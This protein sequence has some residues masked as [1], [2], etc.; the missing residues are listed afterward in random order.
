MGETS[1]TKIRHRL[2]SGASL[3]EGP[4]LPARATAFTHL[5]AVECEGEA[6]LHPM[7]MNTT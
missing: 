4:P 3:S 5:E 6:L 1:P 2:L 7:G